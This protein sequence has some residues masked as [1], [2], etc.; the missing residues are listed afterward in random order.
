MLGWPSGATPANAV[1]LASAS[2]RVA[3]R[4][5]VVGGLAPLLLRQGL[6]TDG[7]ARHR[8][9]REAAGEG[10]RGDQCERASRHRSPPSR[11]RSGAQVSHRGT[12]RPNPQVTRAN[13]SSYAERG[14]LGPPPPSG[15]LPDPVEVRLRSSDR[16]AELFADLPVGAPRR[17]ALEHLTLARAQEVGRE[18]A[19]G[20]VGTTARDQGDDLDDQLP[21]ARARHEGGDAGVDRA[22]AVL[23]P[24]EADHPRARVHDRSQ[25]THG[26]VLPEPDDRD[27][28]RRPVEDDRRVVPDR[29][30]LEARRL[31][32]D[33]LEPQPRD[34]VADDDR[35]PDDVTHA[36]S[37]ARARARVP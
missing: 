25:V 13:P 9:E 20:Q 4:A 8:A 30:D 17:D 7:G 3:L 1:S 33:L 21:V 24:R 37:P 29:G 32:H 15:L 18:G 23:R 11:Q 6:A 36:G 5:D 26:D 31:E 10:H 12:R 27:V 35:D 14:E 2:E 19:L 22:L 16:D 34:V 28:G